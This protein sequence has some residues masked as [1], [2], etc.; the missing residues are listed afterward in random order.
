MCSNMYAP[1]ESYIKR[2]R[3]LVPEAVLYEQLA[4]ECN[5]LAQACLKKARK[6]RGENYTPKTMEEINEALEEEYTDV[7]L[8][9]NACGLTVNRNAEYEK[10]IRWINRS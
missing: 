6:L 3:V 1:M 10:A 8:C 4:E 5:E 7:Q 9:A 2:I